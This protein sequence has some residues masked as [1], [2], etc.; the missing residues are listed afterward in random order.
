MKNHSRLLALTLAAGMTLSLLTVGA[1]AAA[2]GQSSY[3]DVPTTA[4]YSEAVEW[5]AAEDIMN[6]IGDG[7]F[8]PSGTVTR[9]QAVTAIGRMAKAVPTETDQFSDVEANSW[10]SGYVGWAVDNG[11][12]N[13]VGGGRFSPNTLV[14]SE[15]LNLM[16]TRYANGIGLSFQPYDTGAA[17]V[18]RADMAQRLYRLAMGPELPTED[19]PMVHQLLHLTGGTV[20]NSARNTS[21][22]FPENWLMGYKDSGVY[23]FK[24]IKY[25]E[26]DRFMRAV[27]S[28]VVGTQERPLQAMING[29]V[30]PQADTRTESGKDDTPYPAMT[31]SDSDMFADEAGCL[32]L[33]VWTTSLDSSAKKPVLV[34]MH[35]GGY[36]SGS[37]IEL[38]S[39]NGDQFAKYTDV[40][41]VSANARLNVLGYVDLTS[42]GGESNLALSD[43]VLAL[44]WVKANIDQF[45]GDPD[46][47]T[48]MG[49]SGGG[50]KVSALASSPKALEENLFQKV[51]SSSGFGASAASAE[52]NAEAASTV[53][54]NVRKSDLFVNWMRE[55]YTGQ[56]VSENTTWR[57][58]VSLA[59]NA[60]TEDVF[61][62]LQQVDYDDLLGF[63]LGGGSFTADGLYFDQA[64]SFVDENSYLNETAKN[65]TYLVGYTWG[66]MAGHSS[67]GGVVG[68]NPSAIYGMM[69]DAEQEAFM[70]EQ[71]QGRVGTYEE[72]EAAFLSAFPTGHKLIELYAATG[73]G[74]WNAGLNINLGNNNYPAATG[75]ASGLSHCNGMAASVNEGHNVFGYFSAYTMP[76]YGGTTMIH[77]VDLTYFF[78]NTHTFPQQI[79][80]DDVNAR[81]VA[82]VMASALA[83]FCRSGDPTTAMLE[84]KPFEAD[85]GY[86]SIFDVDSRCVPTDFNAELL[87]LCG[88][89]E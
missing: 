61:A 79:H 47:V 39:Y 77:T 48:I 16:L 64:G 86:V 26:A 49:Q 35:G 21:V 34:F 44:E 52:R 13:G 65:Y 24:D 71:L 50:M 83:A 66:E 76:M 82:D 45:G 74:G 33:N 29:P 27:P 23:T 5:L 4:S 70:R 55:K 53:V 56:T 75:L 12:V 1:S 11:I 19:E 36:S 73:W 54:E 10:Y 7:R 37:S 72:I 60:S 69:S 2:P 41:F 89:Q 32:N 30:A 80:G 17:T 63:G 59:N 40:V 8:G 81:K 51:V 85:T 31:P 46:N 22:T 87:R 25:G 20:S 3:S 84:F 67:D 6:G 88:T 78:H 58:L 43:M 42:L 62:F 68:S 38:A 9:A 14:T 15:Q 28:T 18:T 57:Q